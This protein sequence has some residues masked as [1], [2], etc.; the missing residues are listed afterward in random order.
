M[1]AKRSLAT[2][3][4]I[5]ARW[6]TVLLKKLIVTF[7]ELFALRQDGQDCW[8]G[9]A[10]PRTS[11]KRVFGGV[12]IGQAIMAAG[13]QTRRCHALHAFFIGVGE[14]EK[15]YTIAVQRIRDG[16]SFATRQIEIRQDQRLLLIGHTSHHDGDDGPDGQV[17]MPDVAPPEKLEDQR[18]TRI[19]HAACTGKPSRRYLSEEMLDARP[20]K[21]STA[22]DGRAVWFRPR[23]PIQWRAR[24]S[25][26][27]GWVRLR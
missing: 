23:M 1:V 5:V 27:C 25:P 12:L 14:M 21:L 8:T 19:N 11:E 2:V 26:G 4:K 6:H 13:A 24:Y 10:I 17:T 16:G 9:T 15:S 7:N 3:R 22:A 18:F 20:L